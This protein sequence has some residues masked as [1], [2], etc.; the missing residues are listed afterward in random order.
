MQFQ[1]T[2]FRALTL[3]VMTLG[4]TLRAE[5]P[6]ASKKKAAVGSP[7]FQPLPKAVSPKVVL[8]NG[9][10]ETLATNLTLAPGTDQFIYSKTDFTG[11]DSVYIGFYGAVDQDLSKTNY[12]TWW[13]IPNSTQYSAANY[14]SGS[15]FAFLNT[16]SYQVSTFGNQMAIDLQNN[17]TSPV[18][19]TQVTV[20]ANAR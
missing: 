3:A 14:W 15:T 10:S 13:A 8:S 18:T 9:L 12:V 19:Y 7:K 2:R 6:A 5:D 20:W 16:G 4:M 11:A 17:G 1:L